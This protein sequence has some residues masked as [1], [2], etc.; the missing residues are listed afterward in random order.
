MT[1]ITKGK[2]GVLHTS[3]PTGR[4]TYLLHN[5]KLGYF[6]NHA[7]DL[8][9]SKSH[10]WEKS[11][12]VVTGRHIKLVLVSEEDTLEEAQALIKMMTLLE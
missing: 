1:E 3:F 6:I 9:V 11:I 7:N 4:E 10:Y 8:N 2:W 12:A 5:G